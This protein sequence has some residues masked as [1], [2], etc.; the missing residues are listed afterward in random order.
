MKISVERQDWTQHNPDQ[1][2]MVGDGYMDFI[3]PTPDSVAEQLSGFAE[4]FQQKNLSQEI[5]FSTVW[6]GARFDCVYYHTSMQTGFTHTETL[7][8][9][10][11]SALKA[12]KNTGRKKVALLLKGPGGEGLVDQLVEGALVG[13][14]AYR[15]YKKSSDDPFKG[16]EL[17]LCPPSPPMIV[18][19]VPEVEAEVVAAEK[20]EET[21]SA[22]VTI[23]ESDLPEE[24]K[25]ETD[26][27]EP[28][29]EI[30][31][32][33]GGEEA[34]S[35]EADAADV[36]EPEDADTTEDTE[37]EESPEEASEGAEDDS[38]Q[39]PDEAQA[40]Q[41]EEDQ[42]EP[43]EPVA[44]PE[45]IVDEE[46]L[47]QLKSADESAILVGE[48][49]AEGVNLARAL[50]AK[51]AADC[52]PDYLSKTCKRLSSKHGF[53]YQSFGPKQLDTHGYAGLVTVG[54]GADNSPRMAEITYT[55]D[56]DSDVHLVLLGKGVTFDSGG[57]SIKGAK[58][59]HLMVG[60]MSGA[61][62]VI[63]A[64]EVLGRLKPSIKVTAIVVSAENKPSYKSYRPGDI[65]RY[66]N[67]TSVHIE[68]TDAEGRLILA[69]G[70]IR[71]GELGATHIIDLAT[72]TGSCARALGPSFTG[73]MGA[74]RKLVNAITRAGGNH[75]ESY[76]RLPMPLEYKDMLKSVTADINN[77]GGPDAGATTAALFLKEFVPPRTPWA[78]LDIAGTFWK[79]KP[80]KY[81]GEG[82][83]GTGVKTVA[84]L[85]L[86]WTEHLG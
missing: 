78:H 63:G 45:P 55:P 67:G 79:S 52:T 65:I 42:T 85:A 57:I 75:G 80:W 62:A 76:W 1:V 8:T 86:R 74:N 30:T 28:T 18:P 27:G 54:K 77:V 23:D 61:A 12:A 60:D 26:E 50:V 81:Y 15:D 82:P 14:W 46:A 25:E 41:A 66:K 7:K 51:P 73:V 24:V 53:S 9:F 17:I 34:S 56:Q 40:E 3:G 43:P 70:L 31:E 29:E 69:D 13:T 72:L 4:G 33:A 64:M 48:A 49:F 37:P 59:M 38:D 68:N 5:H 36:A 39:E 22:T 84:D 10:L 2:V 32:E 21:A 47:A 44:P 83:S 35:D 16:M 20:D 71:A 58:N 6:D 11:A 19:E